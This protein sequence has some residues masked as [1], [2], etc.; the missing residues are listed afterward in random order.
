MKARTF[1]LLTLLGVLQAA[2]A[3]TSPIDLRPNDVVAFLGGENLLRVQ[4]AGFLETFLSKS[5]ADANLRFRDLTWEGDTVE[6]QTTIHERWREER[7]G[8]WPQQLSHIG[9]TVVWAQFGKMESLAGPGQLDSFEE[10]YE[11][12]IKQ[13]QASVDRI[14]L[15]TPIAFEP[16]AG[17]HQ[18]NLTDA[19]QTLA[20]YVKVIRKL[21]AR[22]KL[23]FINLF[24]PTRRAIRQGKRWTDNGLHLSPSRQEG[25]CDLFLRAAGLPDSNQSVDPELRT[26]VVEKHRL[27]YEYWRPANWKCL[28]GDDGERIFGEA[29][30]IYPTFREEWARYP[31]LINQ[32]ENRIQ[33]LLRGTSPDQVA[34]LKPGIQGWSE[35]RSPTRPAEAALGDF[36][37]LKG[38]E[39][40]LFASETEG[41]INPLALRWDPEGKLY[42]ACT[43]AYPQHEPG[44]IPNDRIIVLKDTN[45]DGK[46][47]FHR[48]F[49]DGLNI[50]TGI[51]IAPDGVYVGQG[52]Q[53]LLLRD[54]DGDDQADQRE[55]VLSGFG[56][57]DT[58]QTSNSFVWSPGG[59]LYWCQGDGIESRVETPWGVSRLFQA[60]VYRL[61]PDRYRL[62]GLLDDFMGPGNPWGIAFDDWGQPIVIDGAGGITHLSPALLATPHRL[63]L[64]T[65]GRP[66]G[67][68][69]I[70]V[71]GAPTL[72]ESM[73]G[74]FLIGDYKPNA[75]SRFALQRDGASFDVLWRDPLIVSKDEYFRPVDV[76][77]GPDGAIYVCDWFNTVICHQDDSYRHTARDKGH[78]R[79]WRITYRGDSRPVPVLAEQSIEELTDS[80]GSRNRWQREQSKRELVTRDRKSV[81]EALDRWS[82]KVDGKDPEAS[83]AR[84]QALM[85]YQSIE[86]VSE[87]AV[88]TCLESPEPRVR[89]Y[90]ARTLGRWGDRLDVAQALLSQLVEDPDPLVRMEAILGCANLG[91]P[92]AVQAAA[93]AMRHPSDPW[94]DYAFTQT[95]RYLEPQWIPALAKGSLTFPEG[96]TD[97]LRI[98]RASHSKDLAKVVRPLLTHSNPNAGTHATV[99]HIL[100]AVGDDADLLDLIT[101]NPYGDR[102][103]AAH[104]LQAEVLQSIVG[105]NRPRPPG[106][107]ASLLEPMLERPSTALQLAAI[108]L[109]I[110]WQVSEL[111]PLLRSIAQSSSS[112]PRLQKAAISSLPTLGGKDA[113]KT[114]VR[115]AQSTDLASIQV[116]AISAMVSL[117]PRQAS[118]HAIALLKSSRF[119][120]HHAPLLRA[121][122]H[123]KGGSH[124]LATA[125]RK[126]VLDTGQAQNL[127]NTLVTQGYSDPQLTEVLR[128]QSGSFMEP[129]EFSEAY[130]DAIVQSVK[131]KGD[132]HAGEAVF[133]SSAANCYACHRIAGVGAELGPDLSATGTGI[134][135]RRLI[136][137][138]VWP[139]RHV[140]EG[141]ALT[142]LTLRKGQ[143]IQGYPRQERGLKDFV[144]LEEFGSQKRI[145]IAKDT[146]ESRE[147]IGSIMPPT[148]VSLLTRPQ[149]RD[150]IRFLSEL[151]SPGDFSTRDRDV[152]RDWQTSSNESRSQEREWIPFPSRVSGEV[153]IEDIASLI[154]SSGPFWIK[155]KLNPD[156]TETLHVNDPRGLKVYIDQQVEGF[157][158]NSRLEVSPGPHVLEILVDPGQRNGIPVRVSW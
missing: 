111:F 133:R 78:G 74:D 115:L 51:E 22:H 117:K 48:V 148:A 92:T 139:T 79:I 98:L 66:G 124:A 85:M 155:T 143:V 30:G 18:P 127:L 15:L 108:R 50:P 70:D 121:F 11:T 38:F 102:T 61:Q 77:V 27:W 116:A 63:R 140:K 49:A 96:P 97:L 146:I 144:V 10:H 112:Q 154:G 1:Q 19:N 3:Q 132:P 43:I 76:K 73:Q 33:D 9:A 25:F 90:A 135:I 122:I 23:G 21:A 157:E 83:F 45:G 100:A 54:T 156:D 114:L 34:Q 75:V 152:I 128:D 69:G 4:R 37:L 62:E 67:Y 28:F 46:A 47:D 93:R 129:P 56:N 71:I 86:A 64:P 153:F 26:A 17:S 53:L 119:Q 82:Q 36:R 41:L 35:P 95:V 137:E 109:A 110:H 131:Q 5:H 107:I 94:I 123:H 136:E 145:Q 31:A 20:R 130:I 57:G 104:S 134:P 103:P 29:A 105:A 120:S 32:A 84:L 24:E 68:S 149:L 99:C 6:V 106:E 113:L 150:L 87:P 118:D 2:S 13:W 40:N 125:L 12:L 60:G 58:H 151:G 8:D 59:Q 16:T 147:T 55:T 72:P 89:A 52:T 138:V 88:R 101:P 44:E 142:Q 39:V 42:V 91:T 141:Y 158:G 65:I 14:T 126:H 81:I 7:Y 80:L